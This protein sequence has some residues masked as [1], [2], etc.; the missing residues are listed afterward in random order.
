VKFA[1]T[2]GSRFADHWGTES[3]DGGAG[4]RSPELRIAVC[5]LKRRGAGVAGGRGKK[6]LFSQLAE[7]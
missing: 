1:K 5:G 7:N 3:I 2:G 4:R 6:C